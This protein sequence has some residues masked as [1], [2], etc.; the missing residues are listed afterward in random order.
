MCLTIKYVAFD[1]TILKTCECGY[2]FPHKIVLDLGAIKSQTF[3][4]ALYE[5]GEKKRYDESRTK[6]I[7]ERRS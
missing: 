1:N 2:R 7:T 6:E 3:L 4:Q 5:L